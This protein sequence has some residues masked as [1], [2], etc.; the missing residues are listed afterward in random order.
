MDDGPEAKRRARRALA[1]IRDNARLAR[2]FARGMDA[3]ALTADRR[4]AYAVTRALELIAGAARRLPQP[5]CD[6]YP[7]VPW[8]AVR[9][10]G[11]VPEGVGEVEIA[12]RLECTIA[13]TLP[14]LLE[15]VEA[16]LADIASAD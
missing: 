10:A 4:T 16:E 3:T 7:S 14:P 12:R 2:G 9:A 15:A 8:S 6:R 1:T 5:L 13:E 11:N